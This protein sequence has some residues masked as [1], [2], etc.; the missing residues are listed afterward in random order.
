[1]AD[2]VVTRGLLEGAFDTHVHS[3]PDLLPRKFDDHEL[4]RR[5][6][7]RKMGGFVLKSHYVCTA[8]RATL[9]RKTFPA[10]Q[11]FGAITLNNSVGGLNPLAVDVAGR[12]GTRVVWLPTVDSRNE[13]ENVAGEKDESKL[14]YW[15]GIAR[16]IRAMGIAGEWLSVTSDGKVVERA[17]QCFEVMAKYDMV[18]ATGHIAPADILPVVVAAKA[19]GVRRIIVT[20]PEFP[21]T[22]LSIAQQA[23]LAKLGAYFERC[24]TTPQSGKIPWETVFANI[25][26][27]GVAST[28]LAT[29]LGQSHNPYVDEGLQSYF[30]KLLDAGFSEG[31]VRRMVRD[32]PAA[33]LGAKPVAA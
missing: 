26:E 21:T 20:H 13:L 10:V 2:P 24:Y 3:A 6:T 9:L 27:V 14:P 25:R 5:F 4:A 30:G 22:L 32:N 7:E 19:A 1:M 23:E 8:D 16:E 15:M 31:E 17:R 11:A 29:D 33:L 12:I 28:I 18:L